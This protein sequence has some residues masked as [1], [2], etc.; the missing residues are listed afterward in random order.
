MFRKDPGTEASDG[1]LPFVVELNTAGLFLAEKA[2]SG[3]HISDG[4]QR[5][6]ACYTPWFGEA[7]DSGRS[8]SGSV[9][10]H[11]LEEAYGNGRDWGQ[12]LGR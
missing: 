7:I 9:A 2:S 4:D 10:S 5:E 8:R 3:H 11:E 1:G 12:Q 6:K